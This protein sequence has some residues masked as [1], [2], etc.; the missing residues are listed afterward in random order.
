MRRPP[1]AAGRPS[2]RCRR[3]APPRAAPLPDAL[4][5]ESV[6]PLTRLLPRARAARP[7]RDRFLELKA[8]ILK[9]RDELSAPRG[10]ALDAAALMG[11]DVP[12]GP[13]KG[14]SS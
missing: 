7:R 10:K 4:G 5:R 6:A 1:P 13:K 14:F 11:E 3:C 2:A 9:R 8:Y 12:A